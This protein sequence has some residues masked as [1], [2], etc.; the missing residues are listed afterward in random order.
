VQKKKKIKTLSNYWRE[1]S[2]RLEH[3]QESLRCLAQE[4]RV[5]KSSAWTTTKLPVLKPFKTKVVP[6]DP[7]NR[8]NF[9][10]W[11]LQSVY[12]SEI[13]RH[14]KANNLQIKISHN[15]RNEAG[16][17]REVF[18]VSQ[19][20]FQHVNASR[21]MES[22]SSICYNMGRFCL[23]ITHLHLVPRSRMCVAIHSLLQY[24][25]MAWWSV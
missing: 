14:P 18:S 7:A 16:I 8:M 13:D 4:T 25:F 19:E 24:S 11:I 17:W 12:D 23:Q 3:T 10:N 2:A 5:S 6:C 22:T 20:E 9:C 1:I 15:W 21:T